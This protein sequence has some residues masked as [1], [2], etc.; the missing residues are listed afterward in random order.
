MERCYNC[1]TYFDACAKWYA[2][3]LPKNEIL[4]REI[5]KLRH[6]LIALGRRDLAEETIDL[7]GLSA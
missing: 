4:L 6:Y 1:E 7:R 3:E 2:D 5:T